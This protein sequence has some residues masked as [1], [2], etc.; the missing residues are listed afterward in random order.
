MSDAEANAVYESLSKEP[1]LLDDL[2]RAQEEGELGGLL[3][4]GAINSN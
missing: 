2:F 1:E 3:P 4:P